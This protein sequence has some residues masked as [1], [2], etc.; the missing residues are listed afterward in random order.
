MTD[1]DRE[2]LGFVSYRPYASGSSAY[3]GEALVGDVH[4]SSVDDIGPWIWS[5]CA[6]DRNTRG[7][8]GSEEEAKAA[9]EVEVMRGVAGMMPGVA[10]LLQSGFREAVR[11]HRTRIGL[12]S[13]AA[14]R[15]LGA[16]LD[17]VLAARDEAA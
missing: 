2:G 3:M 16:L 10:K 9:L 1:M 6:L 15:D 11:Q 17:V 8:A 12:R 7:T 5:V 14:S 4:L 13:D